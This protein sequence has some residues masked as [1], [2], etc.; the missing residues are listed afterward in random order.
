MSNPLPPGSAFP[1]GATFDGRG[2][3]FALFS[4]NAEGVELCLYDGGGRRE[5]ARHSL[6]A[7]SNGVWNGYLAGAEPGLLYGYRVHGPYAPERGHRFNANKLLLDPYAR[8]VVGEY[9]NDPRNLGFDAEAPHEIDRADN[10]DIALKA[11]VVDEKFDWSGDVHPHTPWAGTRIYEAHVRGLTRLHPELPPELRGSYAGLAHPAVIAHLKKLGVTAVELLPVQHFL[12]EPRLQDNGLVNYW[13]YNPVA[14][15]APAQRYASGRPGITP[16]Q[17]FK[18]MVRALHAA[19]IEVILDV[20]FNHSAELDAQGPTLSLRGIDNAS[21]Y[22]LDPH[23]EYE[24]V[25]GCGNALKLEHP[26]VL[27]LVMDSLRFWAG[28]CRVDGFR[29]DLAVTLGRVRGAFDPAAPPWAALVQDPLLARCKFIAEPWDIGAGGYQLGRF[30]AGWGEWN[31]RFRDTMRGFW[32]G[33][34]VS[35]AQFARRFAASADHFHA[36]L[37]E[38][39]AS[40]NYISAHD[41]FTLADLTSYQHK[42]N[43]ANKEQNRDGNDNNLSWNCGVEGASDDP[44]VRLLR[45]QLRKALLATLLLAQGT[46]MLLAGDELG[47]SQQGNNNAYCQDN[48]ITWLDWQ[49]ADTDLIDFVAQLQRVRAVIPAL[50]SRRWWNGQPDS[51]GASDVE[52]LAPSGLPLQVPEWDDTAAG[53]L[54][55]RLS[56]DWLILVNSSANPVP[57]QLPAGRWSRRLS[58]AGDAVAHAVG[59]DCT[60]VARSLAV[61]QLEGVAGVI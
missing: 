58:S 57:F 50:A 60:V 12:D 9:R 2:V 34:G 40:V 27:Q 42:H 7:H 24:N 36:P 32:L 23:G 29:F 48:A 13:G 61:M 37:R 8:A 55:I 22:S 30:P 4:A 6:A 47:N 1:L 28:E 14:W 59:P 54:M 18:E 56:G 33:A 19:R 35:R 45:L 53:A 21:Y 10:A 43:L 5:I 26:R 25:T 44:Q 20:V 3:N 41:G 17:E 31:D 39:S 38:P 51:G 16:L 49:N 52:W 46:P 11:C 15:F